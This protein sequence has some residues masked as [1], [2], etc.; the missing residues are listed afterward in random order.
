M[1]VIN[2]FCVKSPELIELEE[3]LRKHFN[4]YS[5]KFVV[6]NVICEWNSQFMDTVIRVKSRCM[7][8]A[9]SAW[10]ILK[11]LNGRKFS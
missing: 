8:S 7:C 1:C 6:Y 2:R 4:D 10:K 5:K 9:E 11:Y 3:I